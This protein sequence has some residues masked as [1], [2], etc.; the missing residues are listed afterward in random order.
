MSRMH[1]T[2]LYLEESLYERLIR[3]AEERGVTQALIIREA[4]AA[5]TTGQRKRP[6]SLGLGH[7][8]RKAKGQLSERAEELLGGLG[9]EERP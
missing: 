6:R 1:K 5:Y 4:L 8:G 2:T 9:E 7:S 3:L